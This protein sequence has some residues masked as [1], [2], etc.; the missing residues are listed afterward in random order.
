MPNT[1]SGK[2]TIVVER[3]D[4]GRRARAERVEVSATFHTIQTGPRGRGVKQ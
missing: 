3:P 2:Y 4:D 1:S